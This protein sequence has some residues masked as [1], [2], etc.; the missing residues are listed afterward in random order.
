MVRCKWRNGI[1]KNER[2]RGKNEKKITI[3]KFKKI[4]QHGNCR[5]EGPLKSSLVRDA[6]RHLYFSIRVEDKKEDGK[7]K[8]KKN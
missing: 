1:R 5:P 3:K 2:K 6:F 8:K 7:K 4:N